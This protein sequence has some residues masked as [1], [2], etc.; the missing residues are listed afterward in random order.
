MIQAKAVG[1][2]PELSLKDG[3]S[4]GGGKVM[5]EGGTEI[6]YDYLVVAL[7]AQS[8]A[9]GVPGVAERA[10]PFNTLEDALQV[11]SA[12]ASIEE[13]ASADGT[14][15]NV[16]IVGAGYAGV[17]L[18]AVIAERLRGKGLAGTVRVSLVTPG[19]SIM[20]GSP[21]G[22]KQAALD[23][24]TGLSVD[25]VTG[26]RVKSLEAPHGSTALATAALANLEPTA[27]SHAAPDSHT[28]A[29]GGH[30]DLS[31]EAPGGVSFAEA[32]EGLAAGSL[33][34]SAAG[35]GARQVDVDLVLWTAGSS[36]AIKAARKNFPFPI[37]ARGSVQTDAT[38]RVLSHGRVFA[39]GDVC[40]AD[41]GYVQDAAASAYTSP[42]AADGTSQGTS[43]PATAQVA[44]Q[45]A[46][47]VAWNVWASMMGRPLLPFRY[48][49]LGSMMSLGQFNAAV[50][51]PLPPLPEQLQASVAASPL[52]PLLN[53][54]GVKITD[55]VTLEGPLGAAL[56]RAAY[57]YRQPTNEQRI[58]VAA[59]WFAQA[60][61]IAAGAMAAVSAAS[62][63]SK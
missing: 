14:P 46:D 10:L 29:A 18:C 50:A 33:H 23:V 20:E 15:A 30:A 55:G 56:R 1:A 62:S 42:A 36:P 35:A 12:L 40:V 59:E 60:T 22:Q 21:A 28:P 11:Q 8:D 61:N 41:Q 39:L 63:K 25:V 52:G 3:G 27:P 49:H 44:F 7:G 19:Q 13:R 6:E 53:T 9:R 34:S 54:L 57:L 37:N 38:L 47:Y 32:V 17:E 26:T 5:L 45:Q 51:L 58:N 24:L 48:Q 4:S 43:F 16:M 31:P 2:L